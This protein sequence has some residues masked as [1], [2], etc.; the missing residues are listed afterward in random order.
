M[1][2]QRLQALRGSA[3]LTA[4]G[5]GD[6]V[7]LLACAALFLLLCWLLRS[8]VTDDA[9]ITARYAQNLAD[10]HGFA[11]NPGGEPTEGFSNPLLVLVEA[12]GALVGLPPVG[13]ARLVGVASGLALLVAIHRLGPSAVGRTATRVGLVLTA[14][15][16]P[17]AL[18]AVGGLETLPAT[19]ALTVGVLLLAGGGG[20]RRSAVRGGAVLA[21]L[22][23]LRPE[24]V[25]V[26]LAVAVLAEG[27]A[28]L[29][30]GRRGAAVTRLAAA[31]APAIVSQAVLTGLRLVVYGH[32]LPNSAVYKTGWPA[33]YDVL[34][35]FVEQSAPTLAL[36]VV[37]LAFARGR[38]RLLVVPLAIYAAGSVGTI[39]SVNGFSRFLL[40]AWPL[41]AL[42]SG[43]AVAAA[44]RRI[45]R[46]RRLSVAVAA[47]ALVVAAVLSLGDPRALEGKELVPY[48]SCEQSARIDAAEWLR[49]RTAPDAT[50]SISD[51]G[52]VP[53]QAGGRTA[54]DHLLLNERMIQRTGPL[55]TAPRVDWV[56]QRK[57]DVIALVSTSR[58][59]FE[60]AYAID[61]RLGRD[62]RLA[63]YRLA[64]VASGAR[65]YCRY[66]LFLYERAG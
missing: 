60:G 40:P 61:R 11:W 56:F 20:D 59:R 18:W 44:V 3:A 47:G 37:G 12:I 42:L 4:A 23:W 33:N 2:G 62:P 24:G 17:L 9:W 32:L 45:G 53:A 8:F 22:P 15:Y 25:A 30:R 38:Q 6:R 39:D 29:R 57:P 58:D 21:V 14:L 27:P 28:L 46:L 51:A 48:S 35:S 7:L 64:H 50:F 52:L 13:T 41:L 34:A 43:L 10:G 66:H 16:P 26:A 54:I 36:A 65:E 1:L 63:S 19:L 49:S 55:P 31:A 5:R